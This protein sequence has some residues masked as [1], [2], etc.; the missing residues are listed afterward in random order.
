M[1]EL[2]TKRYKVFQIPMDWML[3]TGYVSQVN[4]VISVLLITQ[5]LNRMQLSVSNY[6]SKSKKDN[7]L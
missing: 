6:I 5:A 3:D 2:A 1:R 4:I 7:A